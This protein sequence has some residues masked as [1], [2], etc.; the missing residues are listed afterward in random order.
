[1][2]FV[3]TGIIEKF[4]ATDSF[5]LLKI[6]IDSDT[7]LSDIPLLEK[8]GFT[9]IPEDGSEIILLCENGDLDNAIAILA[10]KSDTRPK[11]LEQGDTCIYNANGDEIRLKKDGTINITAKS[12]V[13][14]ICDDI[15]LGKEALTALEG[16]VRKKDTCSFTGA[17]HPVSS[18][19]VKAQ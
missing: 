17:P 8:Y 10:S 13:N 7:S 15:N 5:Q 16:V 11:N 2:D 3:K 18:T 1:M 14:L 4:D 12:K 9:S 19:K 6:K